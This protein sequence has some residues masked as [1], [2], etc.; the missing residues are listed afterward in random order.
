MTNPNDPR[1][2]STR[3]NDYVWPIV[4]MGLAVL[5][6]LVIIIVTGHN[7]QDLIKGITAILSTLGTVLGGLSYLKSSQA[8][9][10]TN[11]DLDDRMEAA[12]REGITRALQQAQQTPPAAPIAVPGRR[13]RRS[14]PIV[15][16]TEPP[17]AAGNGPVAS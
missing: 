16:P 3:H 9:K 15:A 13:P 14:S 4:V 12:V 7:T 5:A 2:T 10:Q 1:T 17:P 11:G 6:S 8:A